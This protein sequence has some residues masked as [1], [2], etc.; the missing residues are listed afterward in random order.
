MTIIASHHLSAL[1]NAVA[2]V[3]FARS[4]TYQVWS[5]GSL[6]AAIPLSAVV[7]A[8]SNDER[9]DQESGTRYRVRTLSI[10]VNQAVT[11]AARLGDRINY[12]GQAFTV[13]SVDP[14]GDLPIWR[15]VL[16]TSL[17]VQ[18]DDRFRAE[19]R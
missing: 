12:D 18:R 3:G 14:T 6:G 10:Q 13:V 17:G 1:R 8:D 11:T 5:G 2:N 19:G 9:F 15:A 4:L 7:Q 16:E